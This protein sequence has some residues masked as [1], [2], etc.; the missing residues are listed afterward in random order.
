MDIYEVDFTATVAA[1]KDLVRVTTK[2]SPADSHL[3]RGYRMR[4]LRAVLSAAE[5]TTEVL[6]VQLFRSI[7]APMGTPGFAISGNFDV[8]TGTKITYTN[9]GVGATLAAGTV[10]DTGTSATFVANTWGVALFSVSSAG[11]STVTWATNGGSGY[12]SEA[13]ALAALPALPA[14]HTGLG[15]MTVKTS[16][17]S[18]FTAGTDALKTG[19]GGNPASE[20]NFYTTG[21]AVTPGARSGSPNFVSVLGG[22]AETELAQ[23]APV[24]ASIYQRST[25]LVSGFYWEQTADD[26]IDLLPGESLVLRLAGTPASSTAVS[27]ALTVGL[28]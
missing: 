9:G 11:T 27:V 3:P 23:D 13:N 19:T 6:P 1:P 5:T 14:N 16:A 25:E 2:P 21:T 26:I 8:A 20:T 22:F 18:S 24:T 17:G 12:A 4:V 7:S 10:F 28:W 15:H